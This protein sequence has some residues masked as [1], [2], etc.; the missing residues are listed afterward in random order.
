M[1][2]FQNIWIPEQVYIQSHDTVQLCHSLVISCIMQTCAYINFLKYFC[3]HLLRPLNWVHNE[4]ERQ[5]NTTLLRQLLTVPQKTSGAMIELW[6]CI[7]DTS[8][9]NTSYILKNLTKWVWMIIHSIFSM[10][11]Q[12]SHLFL[13]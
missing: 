13:N 10:S 7:K 8:N 3:G 1:H 12:K 5:G 9:I 2:Y 6:T 11:I 4:Q